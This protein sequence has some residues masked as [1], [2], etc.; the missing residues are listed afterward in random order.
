MELTN[1]TY[2][3]A[4]L[5][6]S[7][8]RIA[9]LADAMSGNM[10]EIAWILAETAENFDGEADGLK[11]VHEWAMAAFGFKKATSYNLL[12]IGQEFTACIQNGRKKVY[13]DI[14]TSPDEKG[15]SISQIGKMFRYGVEDIT[16]AHNSGVISPA[17]SC[18]EIEKAL[19]AYFN[20]T[21]AADDAAEAAEDAEPAEDEK[22]V[23]VTDA[24]GHK[25]AIPRKV[26]EKYAETVIE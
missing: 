26:L 22:A 4:A 17:M 12:K 6:K 15:Y 18:R 9:K 14:F 19:A 3:S 5:N 11:N 16:E 21:E 13:R 1:K 2:L 8:A 23:I 10:F 20:G 25:Y 24:D 7:T